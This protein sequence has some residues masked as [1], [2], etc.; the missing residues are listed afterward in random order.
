MRK[1]HGHKRPSREI[2]LGC[3]N[4]E[5]CDWKVDEKYSLITLGCCLC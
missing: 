4:H 3:E 2:K 1:K 5:E